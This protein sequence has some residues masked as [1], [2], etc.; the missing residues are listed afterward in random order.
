MRLTDDPASCYRFVRWQ[1]DLSGANN[2]SSTRMLADR[3]VHAVFERVAAHDDGD[4][5][6]GSV[7]QPD[8]YCRYP[9]TSRL[10]SVSPTSGAQS[11]WSPELNRTGIKVDPFVDGE[12]QTFQAEE[13]A[14][15]DRSWRIEVIGAW[16]NLGEC[17]APLT[18]EPGQFCTRADT[19]EQFRVYAVEERILPRSRY[20][21]ANAN[22]DRWLQ[23]SPVAVDDREIDRISARLLA[24]GRIEF[25]LLP[26]EAERILPRVRYFPADAR[27]DRWLRSSV[28]EVPYRERGGQGLPRSSDG[29]GAFPT[30]YAFLQVTQ[31]WSYNLGTSVNIPAPSADD[32]GDFHKWNER[33]AKGRVPA[34]GA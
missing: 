28:I 4:C 13:L 21:P 16:G 14:A 24:D 9:G 23:S 12:A 27:A 5:A 7:V 1:G 19:T 6:V 29:R 2:P 34:S 20:F 31:K 25:A 22:V 26:V 33:V 11:P 18:V 15:P 10:F 8:H 3:T 32:P 30:A 17:R